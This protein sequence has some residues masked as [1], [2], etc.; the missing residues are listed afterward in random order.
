VYDFQ[1][2]RMCHGKLYEVNDCLCLLFRPWGRVR[3]V[4]DVFS[5]FQTTK[6]GMMEV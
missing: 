6:L 2:H 3:I 1:G 5:V 4:C